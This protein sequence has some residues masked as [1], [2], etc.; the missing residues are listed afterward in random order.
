MCTL[1]PRLSSASPA[2]AGW[3]E[4]QLAADGGDGAQL[5][6]QLGLAR[7]CEFTLDLSV[8]RP[9]DNGTALA[10]QG[11][12]AGRGGTGAGKPQPKQDAARQQQRNKPLLPAVVVGDT[13]VLAAP[14]DG[15]SCTIHGSLSSQHLCTR[16]LSSQETESFRNDTTMPGPRRHGTSQMQRM[17]HSMA[18]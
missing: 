4:Q 15:V 16:E 17:S 5:T 3:Q 14:G 10:A 13:D 11:S 18:R 6:R 1:A 12:A 9:G 8:G 7:R 2:S